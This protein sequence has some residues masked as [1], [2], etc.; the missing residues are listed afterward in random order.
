[1]MFLCW[2]SNVAPNCSTFIARRHHAA[3]Q[4]SGASSESIQ[5]KREENPMSNSNGKSPF[6][7]P[8]RDITPEQ[9][10]HKRRKILAGIGIGVATL[11]AAGWDIYRR[12]KQP[13]N[14]PIPLPPQIP[15]PAQP[16]PIAETPIIAPPAYNPAINQAFRDAGRPL[17]KEHYVLN[18][19]NFYEFSTNKDDVAQ[20]ARGWSIDP[21]SLSIEGLVERPGSLSLEQVEKLGLEERIYRFRCVERWAMTVPWSGV[22]MAALM[23]YV[24]VKSEAKYLALYSV[25]DPQRMPGQRNA[26]FTWPYYEGL[27]MDEAA[28]ELTFIATGLYG[29]RLSPQN[30]SPLRVVIPW[31]YGYK[32]PKSVVR[33]VFTDKKPATFWNDLAPDEYDF[34]ANVD[35][36]V[37]H[38]RWSQAYEQ[39]LGSDEKIPTLPFNGYGEYV[40]KLY[41]G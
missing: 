11:G 27:R 25:L 8:E 18:Y 5:D 34:Y 38:P 28:N 32:G 10:Y 23:R 29:K 22:S 41:G 13:N 40:A 9:T 15:T 3:R 36:T 2:P 12:L 39:V 17:T 19:N 26:Y 31:K 33:M 14:V 30:G 20:I 1:M 7:R 24:G 21:Y 37:P 4:D 16:A 6:Q 35:P